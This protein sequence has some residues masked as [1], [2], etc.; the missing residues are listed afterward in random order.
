MIEVQGLRH[1]YGSFTA[2]AD[3]SFKVDRGE[4]AGFLGPNGAGKTTIMKVLAG[5]LSPSRGRAALSGHDVAR[6][7][8][9]ARRVLGYLPEHCPLYLDMTVS[10]FLDYTAALR[11][12]SRQERRQRVARAAARTG[13]EGVLSQP[14]GELSKGYR[15]RTGLAAAL[16]HDPP[17][18]VLDEPT[19]GLDPLQVQEI[20]ALIREVGSTRTVLFST[21]VLAEVEATCR[22]AIVIHAGKI[23]AD[24]PIAELKRRAAKGS[25]RVRFRP[26]TSDLPPRDELVRSLSTLEEAALARPLEDG[27]F[28]VNPR[29]ST[30]DLA[31]AIFRLAVG[32]GL[33]LLELAPLE[34]SLEDVFLG[35]MGGGSSPTPATPP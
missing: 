1:C 15:Q 14:T 16:V 23:V 2:V 24:G 30:E 7:P 6:E 11:G 25:V 4:V 9:A 35:L 17:I 12:L 27:A 5:F 32:K 29:A 18:L 19:S 22:R 20:R 28:L 10:A 33:A 21:H 31:A 13:I 8:D 3:V 26:G 34:A